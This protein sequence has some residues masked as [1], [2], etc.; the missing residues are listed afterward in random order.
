MLTSFTVKNYRL[1]E[2]LTIGPLGRINLITGANNSGKTALLEALWLYSGESSPYLLMGI[3]DM[4]ALGLA[5]P[6]R[7]DVWHGVFRNY[8]SDQRIEM[9]AERQAGAA[10][11]LCISLGYA[12]EFQLADSATSLPEGPPEQITFETTFPGQEPEIVTGRIEGTNFEFSRI[13]KVVQPAAFLPSVSHKNRRQIHEWYSAIEARVDEDHVL[14]GLRMIEPRL[15]EI[16]QAPQDDNTIIMCRLDTPGLEDRRIP[17]NL[18]GGGVYRLFEILVAIVANPG[19]LVLI[20]EIE[21]GLYHGVMANIWRAIGEVAAEFNVQVFATTH[22]YECVE[23][24]TEALGTDET[25][26]RLHRV[27]ARD[28]R[29]RAVTYDAETLEGAME[30]EVEVR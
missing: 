17:L 5:R 29:T 11:R 25:L 22:S 27:E 14:N 15:T 2:D 18:L 28:G 20:D 13:H 12:S 6:S 16:R 7:L 9:V 3:H 24:A 26:F 21:N 1:F 23:A 10:H 19:G 30:F 8:D 4:R